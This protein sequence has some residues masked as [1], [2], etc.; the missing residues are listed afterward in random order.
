L[1]DSRSRIG[2]STLRSDG[3]TAW[4]TPIGSSAAI[5][6]NTCSTAFSG[7]PDPSPPP[8]DATPNAPATTATKATIAASGRD[9]RRCLRATTVT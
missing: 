2:T 8:S 6:P 7:V 5:A 1:D 4:S 9:A 3:A